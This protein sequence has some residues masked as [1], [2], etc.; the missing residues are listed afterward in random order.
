MEKIEEAT[1]NLPR[2][3]PTGRGHDGR[4]G[5]RYIAG[6]GWSGLPRRPL[7]APDARPG[8]ARGALR[9]KRVRWGLMGLDRTAGDVVAGSDGKVREANIQNL[10]CNGGG[11]EY[12]VEGRMKSSH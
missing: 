11:K 6:S 12:L 4:G 1:G 8:S 5:R 7:L 9:R 3:F 10:R 2:V